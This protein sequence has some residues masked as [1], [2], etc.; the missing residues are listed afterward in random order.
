MLGRRRRRYPLLDAFVAS[1]HQRCQGRRSDEDFGT[2]LRGFPSLFSIARRRQD[3]DDVCQLH[4]LIVPGSPCGIRPT[5]MGPAWI[6]VLRASSVIAF[7]V[8]TVCN[9][10]L[11]EYSEDTLGSR[12]HKR[13]CLRTVGTRVPINTPVQYP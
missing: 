9:L 11:G 7:S 4:V 5:V 2:G 3:S 10:P 12:G 1:L 8:M 13:P 6:S